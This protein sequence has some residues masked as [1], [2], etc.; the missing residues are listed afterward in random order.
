M[1]EMV[2]KLKDNIEKRIVGKGDVIDKIIITLL[3]GGHVL[4]EDVPGVGKTTLARTLADSVALSF[5]RI[6]CTPDTI[7]SDKKN[8]NQ[9]KLKRLNRYHMIK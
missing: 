5:A 3:A 8:L 1:N 4:L 9:A 6:Q 7:P 2:Q